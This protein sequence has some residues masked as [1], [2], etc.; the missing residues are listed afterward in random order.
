MQ[1]PWA[2]GPGWI[3]NNP[4]YWVLIGF[5]LTAPITIPILW[6]IHHVYVL[7]RRERERQTAIT[8]KQLKK[9]E[10]DRRKEIRRKNRRGSK[11]V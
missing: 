7:K 8:E 9:A 10:R 6:K 2:P 5:F 4:L 1:L 3:N 11:V